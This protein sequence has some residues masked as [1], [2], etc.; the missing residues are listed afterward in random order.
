MNKIKFG[1]GSPNTGYNQQ[2]I[3]IIVIVRTERDTVL[4]VASRGNMAAEARAG[5]VADVTAMRPRD[6]L[7]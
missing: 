2:C 3:Q 7:L 5:V 1:S 6:W 4:R